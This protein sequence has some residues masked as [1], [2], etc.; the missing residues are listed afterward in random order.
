MSTASADPSRAES[1]A[2]SLLR[3]IDHPDEL[4]GHVSRELMDLLQRR[5]LL[6]RPE[7]AYERLDNTN[8][9]LIQSYLSVLSLK[10]DLT[11]LYTSSY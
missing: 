5:G 10:Y 8:P 6:P 11:G 3:F 2:A 4:D 9:Y 1:L 7:E